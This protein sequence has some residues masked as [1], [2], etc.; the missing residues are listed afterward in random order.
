MQR[1]I[2][3]RP[4]VAEYDG[5]WHWQS[6]GM[7]YIV[8]TNSGHFIIVDGGM[9]YDDAN[10]IADILFE[11]SKF[12]VIDMWIITHPH[13]DHCTALIGFAQNEVLKKLVAIKSVC[14]NNPE[15]FD[16]RCKND[17]FTMNLLSRKLSCE[18]IKPQ[19]DDIYNVDDVEIRILFVWSD[20][21]GLSDSNELSTVFTVSDGNTK[22]MM[23]GDT[24][25]YVLNYVCNKYKSKPE[26]FKSD[27]VQ[28]PHHGLNGG[29]L[30]FFDL[31]KAKTV[32]VPISMAGYRIVV[33]DRNYGGMGNAHALEMADNIYYSALGTKE[34]INN[35]GIK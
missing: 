27:I 29:T 3:Y 16:E 31:V 17:I 32:L 12:P 33:K 35:T 23:T 9:D 7:G 34:I 1:F 15:Y 25:E 21:E 13:K 10:R 30:E 4:I 8:Q 2:Q 28:L 14:F 5:E 20:L 6:S 24:S 26:L 19:S 18:Y 11:Y 22:I